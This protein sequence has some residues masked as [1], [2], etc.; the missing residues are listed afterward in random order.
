RGG[1]LGIGRLARRRLRRRLYRIGRLGLRRRRLG[2]GR[3]DRGGRGSRLGRR[4]LDR[5]GRRRGLRAAAVRGGRI[6]GERGRAG[7]REQGGGGGDQ[8]AG[9][10][11]HGTPSP[12]Q[13][14]VPHRSSGRLR[15]LV[16][17][18]TPRLRA[19]R[20]RRRASPRG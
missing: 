3:L 6:V 13:H 1:R 16:V 15:R 8:C 20:T 2:L 12:R 5:G 4:R 14:R 19:R 10:E 11:H 18:G 9:A 7:E 17:R